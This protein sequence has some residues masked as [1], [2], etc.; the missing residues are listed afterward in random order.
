MEKIRIKQI[1]AMTLAH[2]R[3]TGKF[4]EIGKA[5]GTLM[6]WAGTNGRIEENS[7]VMTVYHKDPKITGEEYVEQS[8]C[9]SISGSTELPEGIEKMNFPGGKYAVGHFE[10]ASEG[11]PKAWEDV[12]N[13][14]EGNGLKQEGGIPCEL[15]YNNFE[16]HPEKKHVVEICVPVK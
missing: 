10:I 11:F 12:C 4:E 15:Y 2:C 9:I 13:W 14:V 1:P 7:Q 8:A 5:Y 16:E 6:A 3:I